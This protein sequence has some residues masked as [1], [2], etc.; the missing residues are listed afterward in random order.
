MFNVI[1]KHDL[2][3]VENS[4]LFLAEVALESHR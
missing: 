1:C 2:A 3:Y 4:E